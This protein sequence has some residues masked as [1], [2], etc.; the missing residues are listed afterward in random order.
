VEEI[1]PVDAKS[2]D[3]D[4]GEN[5]PL[6][7]EN[8]YHNGTANYIA[9]QYFSRYAQNP[10][11]TLRDRIR[12]LVGESGVKPY[13]SFVNE[14][15]KDLESIITSALMDEQGEIKVVT[16]SNVDYTPIC[17]AIRLPKASYASVEEGAKVSFEGFED[18][19]EVKFE[20]SAFESVALYV[21]DR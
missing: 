21:A 5:Y 12:T 16:V 2:I 11:K 20:L 4:Y 3:G 15:E 14:D 19:V 7:T 1:I 17:D 9:T 13:A 6:L 18:Y 8:K 10:T